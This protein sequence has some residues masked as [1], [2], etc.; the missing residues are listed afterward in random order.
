MGD[1]IV[2]TVS[3]ITGEQ[4]KLGIQAPVDVLILRPEVVE[5]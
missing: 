4:V 1:A 2:I 5:R 3:A